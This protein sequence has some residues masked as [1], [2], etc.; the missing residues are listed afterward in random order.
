VKPSA[1]T[2]QVEQALR[3]KMIPFNQ[4]LNVLK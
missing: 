1:K 4:A 2:E 3:E